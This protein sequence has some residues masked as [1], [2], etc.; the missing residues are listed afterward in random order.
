MDAL[1]NMRLF[2]E[3]ARTSSFRRAAEALGLP[4]STVSRRIAE[5]ERMV[6]L[7]LF[8]RTTRRVEL[9]E[10]GRLYFERCKRIVAEAELAHLELGNLQSRPSG[11]I[12]AS[13]PVDFT[14]I[15]L[16]DVLAE[17]ARLHPGIGFELDLT[18]NQAD[19]VGDGVD[20]AIRMGPPSDQNL[21]A[22][23]I[24]RLATILV[25]SPGYLARRGAPE[26]P[27]DL[28]RHECLR[29]KHAPWTLVHRDGRAETVEVGGQVVAN[30]RG[31]L[32]NL[33]LRDL[34]IIQ[35]SGEDTRDTGLV[36]VLR[37]W[38]PPPVQAYALTTTRLLPARVRV[39]LDFLVARLQRPPASDAP[40]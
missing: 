19:L 23:P 8:N 28:A 40:G 20:L 25:A 13:M 5:L 11:V 3:V 27:G 34:G 26:V 33:A 39:F 14:V 24:A 4:S 12:R 7:P 17:F 15:H 2:V 16:S 37:D 21:I 38:T 36:R 22:R 32:R 35:S 10:G 6:G 18:P 1:R 29:M 31:L 30:N 9:T